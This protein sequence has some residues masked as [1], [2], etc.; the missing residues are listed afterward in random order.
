M[1][2]MAQP[3][4][5]PRT[6]VYYIRIRIPKDVKPHLLGK[7]ELYK[8]SLSTKDAREAKLRFVTEYARMHE[9]FTN[10]RLQHSGDYAPN[11]QDALQLASRWASTE[12]G[13]M[14]SSGDFTRYLVDTG[15]GEYET[16]SEAYDHLGPKALLEPGGLSPYHREALEESISAELSKALLPTPQPGMPF[17]DFLHEVFLVKHLE[18][19]QLA[20]KRHQGNFSAQIP[21]RPAAPLSTDRAKRDVPSEKLSK[22]FEQWS[23]HYLDMGDDKRDVK[24]TVGEYQTTIERFIQLLGDLPVKQIKR[25][26]I[27]DFYGLLRQMP[28]KGE[29]IRK[30]NAYEQIAK[31]KQLGLPSL[32]SLTIKNKL[33]GL[34]SV[35]AYALKMELIVENPVIASGITKSLS[36]AGAKQTRTAARK[37]YTEAEL[38]QVFSSPVFKGQWTP[39][40]ASF[41]AAWTWL[42]LL[43]CYTGARREEIAQMKAN[44]VRQS[45]DGIWHLD[46]LGTADESADDDRTLKT[47]GS[48]RLVAL[49]QDLID[50]GFLDYVRNLPAKGQLFPSLKA[51]P[52]GYYGHNFGKHWGS[53]VRKIAELDSPVSS[54]HGFRHTFKTMCRTAG[55]PEEIHDAITG[56]DDGS[57]S[58][59]YGERHLLKTQQA[60]L[61]RLPRIAYLS[62]LL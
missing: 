61:E 1:A 3:W 21:L 62:G 6:G 35:L 18:L 15:D 5:D 39:P 20:Y 27:E 7:G 52:E 30:L 22:V 60:Q 59:K 40:R 48:H 19:S 45:E 29:G 9:L 55:I 49:H 17:H 42:P 23:R 28:T 56:H 57:V 12:L 54:S 25:K 44:E 53:Y 31:A 34:S 32:S 11:L 24:K 41:G 8:R 14:E 16:L 37:G 4:K 13:L 50:L 26:T 51:N 36:K 2:F 10:A 58:R 43:L 47:N 46:L 38:I 33:M